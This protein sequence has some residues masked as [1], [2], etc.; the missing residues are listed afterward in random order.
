MNRKK[1]LIT[2]LSLL[3]VA[4]VSVGATLAYFSDTSEAKSNVITLGHVDIDLIDRLPED[5]AET[6]DDHTWKG[7]EG[8]DGITYEDVLPGD[9]VEKEVGFSVKSDSMDAWVAIQV[10]T[11]VTE[12]PGET[13]TF[14]KAD[15]E[16][17][18]SELI[19]DY[20][21]KSAGSVWE[22]VPVSDENNKVTYYFRNV[23]PGGTDNVLLFDG[24]QIPG[25]TWD[26]AYAGVKFNVN[27]QA[28]AVQADNV[29]YTQFK[30]M[31]WSD[32]KQYTA[33]STTTPG[34]GEDDITENP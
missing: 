4:A 8:K 17:E 34:T 16:K 26:N 24:I 29:S 33:P 13:E 6:E 28:V 5:Y 7:T 19:Q 22:A 20:V 9:F 2:V 11:V 15:V 31:P 3:L 23:A 21:E 30:A 18:L 10:Q 14:T 32:F 1:L 12:L 25:K 27:V